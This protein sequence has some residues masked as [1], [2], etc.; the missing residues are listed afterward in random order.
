V[1]DERR[2]LRGRKKRSP[3]CARQVLFYL[4]V[5]VSHLSSLVQHIAIN[6]ASVRTAI[7]IFMFQK[8]GC[9]SA[10][11]IKISSALVKLTIRVPV[12]SL[13]RLSPKRYENPDIP[14]NSK[15]PVIPFVA[16]RHQIAAFA[17]IRRQPPI[18]SSLIDK[19]LYT[20]IYYCCRYPLKP[21][22]LVPKHSPVVC[23]NRNSISQYERL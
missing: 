21:R 11:N 20:T 23:F 4:S 1:R 16:P 14:R 19:L 2:G 9:F 6:V 3:S 15:S 7:L 13:T 12:R 22:L 18:A 8:T 10:A 17:S 5:L